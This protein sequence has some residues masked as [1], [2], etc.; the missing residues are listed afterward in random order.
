MSPDQLLIRAVRQ[1]RTRES[2]A[3][4]NFN[5]FKSKCARLV[6]AVSAFLRLL[7]LA[8]SSILV[9]PLFSLGGFRSSWFAHFSS[10]PLRLPSV[11]KAGDVTELSGA[12]LSE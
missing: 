7:S 10:S 1:N 2:D 12:E 8:L 5:S 11:A 4:S 9:L 3:G 6:S